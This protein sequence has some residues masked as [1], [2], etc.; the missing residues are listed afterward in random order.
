MQFRTVVC[1]KQWRAAFKSISNASF[2]IVNDSTFLAPIY[3]VKTE[4]ATEKMVLSFPAANSFLK[5]D[6][7]T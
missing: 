4:S 6:L 7:R 2:S 5:P 1:I 3:K